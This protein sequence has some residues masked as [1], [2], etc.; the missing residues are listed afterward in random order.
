MNKRLKE[1]RLKAG[2]RTATATIEEC[3]WNSTTY[4]AHESGQNSFKTEDAKNYG[5]VYGVTPS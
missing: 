4:W 1:A 3:G 2:F 5:E